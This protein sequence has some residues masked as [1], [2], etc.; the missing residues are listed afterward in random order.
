M[1]PVKFYATPFAS[2]SPLPGI[3]SLAFSF[4][5]EQ[6]AVGY[7]NGSIEIYPSAF[8]IWKFSF[9]IK[10]KLILLFFWFRTQPDEHHRVQPIH[11]IHDRADC[12][13]SLSFSPK[14]KYLAAGCIDG[15][16]SLYAIN[17]NKFQDLRFKNSS[18]IRKEFFF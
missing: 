12:I 2:L 7:E 3:R 14:G 5:G 9:S 8:V 18:Q 11:I 17:G 10:E 6:I 13:Q 15:A 16:F 4:N 1:M